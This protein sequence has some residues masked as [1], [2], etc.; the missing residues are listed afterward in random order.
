MEGK[1]ML[2]A[3]DWMLY[4]VRKFALQP[5][6]ATSVSR[7]VY[8]LYEHTRDIILKNRNNK[9]IAVW[10]L[11]DH[12]EIGVL[13]GEWKKKF[14]ISRRDWPYRQANSLD[15]DFFDFKFMQKE[16]TTK[17][18]RVHLVATKTIRECSRERVIATTKASFTLNQIEKTNR[19]CVVWRYNEILFYS[20]FSKS[21]VWNW[22]L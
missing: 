4:P 21:S 3:G 1:Q 13:H 16:F 2:K 10:L 15:K 17:E 11:Y 6:F 18:K 20:R 22:I 19:C 7:D 9:S 8:Y 12:P 14:H 5:R